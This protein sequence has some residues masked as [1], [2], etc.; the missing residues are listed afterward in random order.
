MKQLTT[1]GDHDKI[2]AVI[3]LLTTEFTYS[4]QANHRKVFAVVLCTILFCS[5]NFGKVAS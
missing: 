2:T 4:P 5:F 1:A 3:N